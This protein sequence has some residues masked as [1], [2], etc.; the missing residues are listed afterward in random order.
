MSLLHVPTNHRTTMSSPNLHNVPRVQMIHLEIV[1]IQAPIVHVQNR[2]PVHAD[3]SKSR[4]YVTAPN[5]WL[6][7]IQ[8]EDSSSSRSDG[9]V[10]PHIV[11]SLPLLLQ[12]D[13]TI[14]HDLATHTHPHKLY[15]S[16]KTFGFQ[17]SFNSSSR[18]AT[19]SAFLTSA[20]MRSLALSTLLC[21]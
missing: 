11:S 4:L 19:S 2:P 15:R 5:A 8:R 9:L 17:P 6:C 1:S 18:P 20:S 14:T 10:S 12:L 21:R 16:L 3:A 7:R 13:S